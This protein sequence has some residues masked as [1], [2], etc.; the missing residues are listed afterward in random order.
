M[1]I[2][3]VE[4]LG[5]GHQSTVMHLMACEGVWGERPQVA[6]FADTGWEPR[7]VYQHLD[8]LESAS[9][10]PIARVSNGRN[11]RDDSK[12]WKNHLG[13]DAI[14]LPLF[15]TNQDGSK[16]M[17]QHRQCTTKYKIFPIERYIR[18]EVLKLKP[19]QHIPR[20]VEVEEWLGITTD[21]AVRMKDNRTRG[22][23]NR[24][25]LIELGMTRSDCKDWFAKHYPGRVLPRSAC[26]GCPFRSDKE[27]KN[28][29]DEN[30]LDF[31]ETV[32]VDA[33][34]RLHAAENGIKGVP[35]LHS[36]RKPLDEAVEAYER[37]LSLNPQLPGLESGASNECAGVCFV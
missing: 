14:S 15:L 33:T 6:I 1:K 21:E 11:L 36:R 4:S 20:D 13:T 8:W 24:Y 29:K 22:F 18:R 27:W 30:P 23:R 17:L 25:P 34:L 35:Y 5:G 7:T 32:E 26:S 28:L 10:M 19:R 3:R 2:Y 12:N 9:S 31:A 16:G 37:A